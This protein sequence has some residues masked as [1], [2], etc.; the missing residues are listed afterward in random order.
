M[1]KT[2][3][4]EI[5]LTLLEEKLLKVKAKETGLPV[6]SYVRNCA[7]GKKLPKQL[8]ESELETYR[9]LKKFYNN[10][11]SISN[12]LKKGDYGSM[13]SEISLV[14]QEILLHLQKIRHDK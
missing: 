7:L 9:E 13:L 12:L 14:Q 8:N 11:S 5:R 2:K 3:R 1:N 4:I 10:F 6:S